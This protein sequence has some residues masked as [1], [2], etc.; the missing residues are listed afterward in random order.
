M[1]PTPKPPSL[2][3]T[4][5][6]FQTELAKVHESLTNPQEK[7]MLGEILGELDKARDEA[8]A[9]VKSHLEKMKQRVDQ[10]KPEI[11]ALLA[12]IE[13]K[14]KEALAK[15][16]EYTAKHQEIVA[17]A[18]KALPKSE[19]V[20]VSGLG[21]AALGAEL[22]ARHG[23]PVATPQAADPGSLWPQLDQINPEPEAKPATP[24]RPPAAPPKAAPPRTIPENQ[25]ASL[26]PFLD[27]LK[28]E[29][30]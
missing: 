30:E 8:Q 6:T 28:D 13:A 15:K 10:K 9:V 29:N 11:E 3:K 18:T 16:Q 24:V 22:L 2:W 1:E 20:A 14:T 21:A 27:E 23:S 7:Q 26:W 5:E 12:Q 4:L 19:P 17:K 25:D